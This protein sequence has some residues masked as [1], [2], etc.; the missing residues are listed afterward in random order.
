MQID[1]SNAIQALQAQ[2]GASWEWSL[3]N[4]DLSQLKFYNSGTEIPRP[5]DFPTD[6]TINAKVISLQAVADG[7]DFNS[8]Q[9]V[10]AA[11]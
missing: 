4:K 2:A 3:S 1:K 6:E 7:G 11:Q 5:D 8:L 10:I 9:E